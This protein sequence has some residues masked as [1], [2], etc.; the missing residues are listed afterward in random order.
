MGKML[1]EY[2]Q[3]IYAKNTNLVEMDENMMEHGANSPNRKR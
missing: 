3:E 2:V 1:R